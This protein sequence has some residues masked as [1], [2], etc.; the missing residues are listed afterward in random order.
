MTELANFLLARI[1]EDE[2]IASAA[3]R[4]YGAWRYNPSKH[5]V[6]PTTGVAEESVFAGRCSAQC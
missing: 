2:R 1:A 3:L 6:S 4:Y 5:N